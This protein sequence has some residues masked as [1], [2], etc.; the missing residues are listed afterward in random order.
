MKNHNDVNLLLYGE[1]VVV[2]EDIEALRSIYEAHMLDV[3]LSQCKILDSTD[4][5]EVSNISEHAKKL[6]TE[7]FK[8]LNSY[9]IKNLES[10]SD[11]VILHACDKERK[12]EVILHNVFSDT[13]Y[14]TIV[15]AY[16]DVNNY[17][18]D[19]K[20]YYNYN[21]DTRATILKRSSDILVVS[22]EITTSNYGSC[23]DT[24]KLWL[25]I[26]KNGKHVLSSEF[27]VST[28]ILKK[29]THYAR[30]VY[31]T[32]QVL[33]A[34]FNVLSGDMKIHQILNS[35]NK[36]HRA[37]IGGTLYGYLELTKG[38]CN[39]MIP[40]TFCACDNFK[41]GVTSV[42]VPYNDNIFKINIKGE[43]VK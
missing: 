29:G 28:I 24:R 27:D 17:F 9:K 31:N 20:N 39:L 18:Y 40:P 21:I 30:L 32:Y 33:D 26:N 11:Y 5:F 41:N 15:F 14:K 37:K 6:E 10:I 7:M 42:K 22:L 38:K 13:I 16:D 2:T 8:V 43:L 25:F 3:R 19:N 12:F 23:K 1:N 36:Y 4:I 35:P 34:E